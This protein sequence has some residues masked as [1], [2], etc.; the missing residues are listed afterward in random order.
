MIMLFFSLCVYWRFGTAVRSVLYDGR[1]ILFI[2]WLLYKYWYLCIFSRYIRDLISSIANSGVGCKVSD[3]FINI[4]AYADNIVLIAPSWTALQ[5]LL[6]VLHDKA[7]AIN[8]ECNVKKT[9]AVVFP[10]KN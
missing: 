1:I 10:L 6:N 4:L 2:N 9:V 8:L 7:T 3:H 5:Q